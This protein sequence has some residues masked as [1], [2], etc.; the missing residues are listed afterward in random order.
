MFATLNT[1][2]IDGDTS[3]AFYRYKR[4]TLIVKHEAKHGG[5]TRLE[6]LDRICKQLGVDRT[7]VCK[8]IQKHLGC[9]RIGGDSIIQQGVN[10][11]ARSQALVSFSP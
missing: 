2:H 8:F 10:S 4:D 1:T 11:P 5:Q 3:D 6:N 9:T 7:R